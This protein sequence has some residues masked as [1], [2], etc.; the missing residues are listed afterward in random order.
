M[1]VMATKATEMCSRNVTLRKFK[2]VH[3]IILILC[4]LWCSLFISVPFLA[5]GS[6][7]SRRAAAMITLFFSPICHQAANRSFHIHGHSLAVCARCTGIYAGFL[8]GV[9]LYPFIRGWRNTAL[10]SNWILIAGFIPS[11][12]EFISSRLRGVYPDP[13]FRSLTGSILGGV[14]SIFV[15]PAVFNAFI[16][17]GKSSL[18]LKKNWDQ[19]ESQILK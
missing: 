1:E 2:L 7:L 16:L 15:V 17:R 3:A 12:V 11:G 8:I 9:I 19:K 14:V 4:L 10:P 13:L 6:S 18:S 5:E